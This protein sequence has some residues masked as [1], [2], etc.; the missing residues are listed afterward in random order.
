M[1]LAAER[2][3]VKDLPYA[4]TLDD[5]KALSPNLLLSSAQQ[6]VISAKIS[7]SGDAISRAGDFSG[8]TGPVKLG[9]TGVRVEINA[10]VNP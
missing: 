1:P 5:S 2:K 4:F 6:L 3:Q 10:P 7:K 8:Q 9:A